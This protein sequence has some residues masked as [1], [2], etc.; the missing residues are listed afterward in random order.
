MLELGE[1]PPLLQG[2]GGRRLAHLPPQ[3]QRLGLVH[4]PDQGVDRVV[5]QSTKDLQAP[6]AVDDDVA[7]RLLRVGHDHDGLLLT[8]LFQRHQQPTLALPAANAQLGVACLQLVKLQLHDGLLSRSG[9]DAMTVP[10][11]PPV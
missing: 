2:T 3:D 11:Y 9:N 5:S 10:G 1:Q 8:V 7:I 4:L 6:V